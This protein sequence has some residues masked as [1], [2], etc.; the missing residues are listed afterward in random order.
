VDFFEVRDL[1]VNIFR[2]SGRTAKIPDRG[3]ILEKPEGL[4]AKLAKSG[5]RVDF[6]K[7]QGLLCK[8]S[9]IS[10]IT[11]YVVTDNSWTRSTSPWTGRAHSVHHGLM[12]ERTTVTAAR[13]LELGLRPFR[14]AKAHRRVRK[15]EREAQGAQL[16][17][18]R[19]SS[20][21]E[22]GGQRRCRA[23]RRRCSV[24]EWVKRGDREV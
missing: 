22:E 21:V 3:L 1:F 16:G 6:P 20:G 13:S 2:I 5:P 24:R 9:E 17:P 8:I 7:V 15:T 11:N 19:S 4:S 18:H 10:E 14:W 12:L 23:G